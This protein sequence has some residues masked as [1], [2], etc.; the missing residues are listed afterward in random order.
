MSF[1][2]YFI[3]KSLKSFFSSSFLNNKKKRSK[4]QRTFKFHVKWA[5]K[6]RIKWE[7]IERWNNKS[8]ITFNLW[9]ALSRRRIFDGIMIDMFLDK[10]KNWCF[11]NYFINNNNNKKKSRIQKS[12]NSNANILTRVHFLKLVPLK[13]RQYLMIRPSK[14]TMTS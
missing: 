11:Y 4:N 10:K 13:R 14:S 2:I 7:S 12:K 6:F 1:H 8:T 9:I 5:A 3:S